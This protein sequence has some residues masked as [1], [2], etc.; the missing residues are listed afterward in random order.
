MRRVSLCKVFVHDQDEALD[1]Y[2]NKLGFEVAED[3]KLGLTAGC[4]SA[5][6]TTRSSGSIWTSLRPRNRKRSS[7]ARLRTCRCSASR[8]MTV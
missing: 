4:S 1:F 3:N 2:T 7:A 6:P 8:P 5:Y